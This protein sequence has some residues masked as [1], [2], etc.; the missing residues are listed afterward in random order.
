MNAARDPLQHGA[1]PWDGVWRVERPA[2]YLPGLYRMHQLVA[3]DLLTQAKGLSEWQAALLQVIRYQSK[4]LTP[5]QRHYLDRFE[6][7]A[8]YDG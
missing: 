5:T 3:H 1:E 6:K 4:P 2:D 7:E 8:R